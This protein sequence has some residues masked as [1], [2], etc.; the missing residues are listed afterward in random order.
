ML[1]L[2]QE[3][4]SESQLP[5]RA[6]GLGPLAQSSRFR[7]RIVAPPPGSLEALR[8]LQS[9]LTSAARL[10]SAQLP[11][12]AKLQLLRRKTCIKQDLR[13]RSLVPHKGVSSTTAGEVPL[14]CSGAAARLC[15][16][17]VHT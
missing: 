9:L 13:C 10:K 5:E 1:L 17:S 14:G 6:V 2:L 16:P 15:F 7:L 8:T 11:A 12:S 3:P 4:A